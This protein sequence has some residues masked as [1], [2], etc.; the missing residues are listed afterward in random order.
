[1]EQKI[2]LLTILAMSFVTILTKAF[3][4]LIL[5]NRKLPSLLENF[6]RHVPVAILTSMIVQFVVVKNNSINFSLENIFIWASIP[7]IIV[8]IIFRS[9]FITV[10]VGMFTVICIRIGLSLF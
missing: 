10:I 2:I 5:A 8:A 6:L 7:T 9:I 1:M 4:I 3:P